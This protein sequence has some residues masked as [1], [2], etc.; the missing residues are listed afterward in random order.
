M[1][2]EDE[3]Y[4]ATL[5]AGLD[6]AFDVAERAKRR[7]EDPEPEVEIPVAKDMADRVENILGIDGVAER[8]RDLEGE[9]SREEAALELVE[10]FV[11]GRVG[12]YETKAGKVE[13]AVRTAVA[14]LTEG[15]VAAPIEGIDRVEVNANDDGT[16]Y[17]AVYYAGPIRSAGGTAQALSVLVADYARALLDIDRFKPR[18]DEI[19]RYAEEVA[20]YDSETGLQYSPKDKETK[21]ITE[22]CPV[23]LDGEATGD[24]EVDGFRDLERIAT[25]S[26]RGGMCLVLAEGIALKAPKIQRY[27]RNLDEV[28]WP[29]LQDLIDGT[30]GESEA[31][32]GEASEDASGEAASEAE[33]ADADDASEEPD[34]P[35]RVDPS[36]KFLRDLIA[37]RPVFG[38]PSNEGGFR[39]RYGRSRN[40]GFATAGIHPAT[41]H[42]VDDFL[43]TG[44]QI[45]TERPGKAAGIVPVDSIEGPTV[46]LANGD[47]RRIDDP[48]EALEVRNGVVEI[49]DVGEYLVNYG[50]F[51]ENNHELAPASYA[52]EWWI[53]DFEAAGA[54]IQAL[55]DSPYVDLE[56]PDADQALEWATDYDAPLH[57]KY[58]HL[59]HDVEVA[60]FEVLADAVTDA[61][62]EDGDLVVPN[63]DAVR[64][65]LEALLVEHTQDDDEIRIPDW[66][67]FARSLG[68]TDDLARE[69]D[70]LSADA[71]EWPNAL[72]AVNEVAPFEVR[73]RAPTRIGNRMGRPEKS[74]SR[75]LSPAVHT[76]FPIGEAG[77]SQR[78]VS[79]AA[80]HAPDMSDTPGELDV[81]L[82]VRECPDCG[83]HTFEPRC[84]DCGEW[85]DPHYECPDCNISADPDESGRVE[86]PRCEREL[87]NVEVQTVDVGAEYRNALQAVG[88]REN[89]FDQ[90]KGV[91]GLM[92][93]E[94]VPE[95]ME[96]GVL[97]A[98]HD[99]SAFK[100]GTVRYDMTDLPVTSVKPS[101]LDVTVEHFRELGYEE[102]I[103]GDPLEH[104]DQLVEL[105]VQDIV[106][107]DGAAEHMLQT[108]DFVDDLLT[109][110]YGLDAF[111]E[112]EERD[113]LVGELVF[114]M[115]PHTS[116]AVVG[117]VIGFTSASVGYAHPYFHAAKR[118][119]CFHPETKVWF[120]DEAGEWHHDPIKTLV[121]NRLDPE[122]ADEDDF[123]TLVQELDGD[124]FVP[125]VTEDGDVVQKPVEAVSKHPA[126]DHMVRIEAESGRELTVTPDHEVQYWTGDGVDSAEACDLDGDESLLLSTRADSHP[127][128]EVA[129]ATDGGSTVLDDISE[130]EYVQSDTAHTYCLTVADTHSLFA[131]GIAAKQCDGDEDCV[132]LLM[133]GLINFSKSYLP[134]QRGGSV[135]E[136]SRLVAVDPDGD[137]RFLTFE[138]F[139]SELESP[140]ETDGKFRKRTCY[141]EGWQ[142]YAFDDN[143]E[144]SLEPIEKAIRYRADDDEQLVRVETQFGRSLEITEHHSLFRYDDGIE[145]VA[146]ADL[147]AGDLVVAPRDLDVDTR[148]TTLDVTDCV[149]DPYVVIDDD[150]EELLRTAWE[151]TD[152]GS[153]TH[154]AF[155]AGLAYR[156]SKSKIGFERFQQI[157]AH[158]ELDVPTDIEIG[159]EGSSL[160]ITRTIEVDEDFA[161]LLGLFVAEGTTSSVNPCIHN[162]DEDLIDRAADIATDKLG[163]EPGRRWS[164]RAYELRF[165]AVFREVLYS[166]GFENADS[167]DSSEKVVP[168]CILH[169]PRSVVLDFLRGFIAGDGSDSSNDNVTTVSFHTTSDD[170]KDGIMFLL[171]RLGLVAN[172]STKTNRDGNRQDIHT[173][174]VSGGAN[175]NPLHRLLDG[176]DPYLPKSLVVSIP[177]TLME[178]REMDIAGV[179][180]TIPKYLK[181]RDNISLEKLTEIVD[182]LDEQELPSQAEAALEELRPLVDGDLSYLRVKDIGSVDYDGYLYD[183]Q[184]GGDPVFTA[185]WLYAHN[186]M[187]APLVMSSRIDPTEIDDEAHNMD[188]VSQYP[189]EFYEATREMADP[190]EVEDLVEIAEESLG[191]DTEYAGFEHTHDTSDIHL[192]PSLSA[193]KTLGSM[194]DKMDA[195]LE[196]ARKLR[197]V[198]ETDVAERVIEY[199]FLPDLIGN[200][201]AF[202]RQETRCLDCGEKY[203]RMP[204]TGDCRECGGRVNLTVHEGSVNK[205]MDTAIT[206]AE[207]Y[208]CREYTKQRLEVLEASLESIFENDKNKQ[209]GIADFM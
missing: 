129:A 109:Q 159:L 85:T 143:H 133:D 135:A 144:A 176:D 59:W 36:N 50:E 172:V 170:V 61:E 34:G 177:S 122:T 171:H 92:S 26:A 21:F 199:H 157:L 77:G 105:R 203:R 8:V 138:E 202:S 49:L 127:E 66:R 174:T 27:T 207:E 107:S 182:T 124:V 14:L 208:D 25:N 189:R 68:L 33:A 51:V 45:K 94:K 128:P 113:D 74:E 102:D 64:E 46:K 209:S 126:P 39:L 15:V 22:H 161:W 187:D 186:S 191:T 158:S 11:E 150:V 155:D 148:E 91:Q 165:P 53:Q 192:G 42:L 152:R 72:A 24:E 41:M 93:A 164:N 178:L 184:V 29:W 163:T 23:M 167:Y 149:D 84:E 101:E 55:R 80:R 147:E 169:A 87:D 183:L 166:L 71:R 35:P 180:Q 96:K 162:A 90:L 79:Q 145:E 201:R 44:T 142:T 114:G 6:E 151:T 120:E 111:Y 125:S 57:P 78:D 48:E 2:P 118:R 95:P 195:Q 82:G 104:D 179:K 137:V 136:D 56:A 65:P 117:R 4:F 30:I 73:E 173:V 119:N 40:H 198:D 197:A 43:A 193:Y 131:N 13:G 1:R 175:D 81:Q 194:M 154:E 160:G 75:D 20:L 116:A 10:D 123:G 60:D 9:M 103:H 156:L 106:L 86:C 62:Q 190:G 188:V 5:E 205:Y 115:A 141:A 31:D 47:V 76:L 37:G 58:T 3:A 112:L 146:G 108:A 83:D 54:D 19:E 132:M 181:R 69:W 38:H 7:G 17:V 12:D 18:D 168:E 130:I 185:N 16:E 204:L 100:D 121:E 97:R 63:E 196:L 70:D 140:I 88:E 153:E 67:P 98:K 28:E 89:A 32:Q 206:V 200:L 52:P 139:W 134:D 99:V 110:Y